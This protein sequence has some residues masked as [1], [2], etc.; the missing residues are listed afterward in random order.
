MKPEEIL[1][2]AEDHG[3]RTIVFTEVAKI[4]QARP[5]VPTNEVYD[6]AWERVRKA[7]KIK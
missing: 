2:A 4:R 7:Y 1:L 3:V 6:L 5:L